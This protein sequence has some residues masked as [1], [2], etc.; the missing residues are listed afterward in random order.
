MPNQIVIS[1]LGGPEVLKYQEYSLPKNIKN[2]E[3]RIK[4]TA[5]G[6][7]YIDTYHRSGIYPLPSELPFCL[8][9]EAAGEVIAIG[10]DVINF[11]IGDRVAYAT[12]PIGAYCEIRDFPEEKLIP[13]P[14]YISDDEAASI[15]LQGMT[16][17]YLFE[18][19]YKIKKDEIILFHAAA[20]GVGLIACQWARSV[21]CKMI[22]T[23]STKEKATHAKE[24]GCEFIIN[25][26][27]EKVSNKV[28]EITNNQGVPV[29]YDGVGKD[30]FD[31]S[32]KCLSTRG[33]MVSFGQSSGMVDKIDMHKTFNPKSLFYTRPS[34]M[35]YT[36]N[37]EELINC[38]NKVF[39][40][41]KKGYVKANIYKKFK[42]NEA[43][44]AHKTLQSRKSSGS[45]ILEP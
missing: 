33:L 42:L 13:I 29:V 24:H 37:R 25:Y 18:R 10:E 39:D 9:M 15:L 34:L 7:N 16:V 23:V 12:P 26:K 19:L 8:G 35:G 20:G 41:M 38:S 28:M 1:T 40:K 4:Q 31:E 11:K 44:E 6:L 45:I 36:L 2:N 17:E 30:T 21:G 14:D 3:V 32:I 27:E 43:E 5:I 22:G